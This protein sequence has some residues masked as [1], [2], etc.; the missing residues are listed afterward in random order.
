MKLVSTAS[1]SCISSLALGMIEIGL[2]MVTVHLQ[3]H[4]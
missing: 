2:S 3:K 1:T 4:L